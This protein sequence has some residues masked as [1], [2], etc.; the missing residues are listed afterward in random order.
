MSASWH[1]WVG[2]QW[3]WWRC[4]CLLPWVTCRT[5]VGAEHPKL[6]SGRGNTTLCTA[7]TCTQSISPNRRPCRKSNTCKM[8][9]GG[10]GVMSSKGCSDYF[11]YQYLYLFV[12]EMP[13]YR[14]K[15]SNS[16]PQTSIPSVHIK[17]KIIKYVSK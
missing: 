16:T 14:G 12:Y 13:F 8:F 9:V 15:K 10:T 2:S 3:V 5:G 1:Q 11:C 6:N 17:K 7:E 4:V